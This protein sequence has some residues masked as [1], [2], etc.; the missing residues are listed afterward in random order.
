MIYDA[1]IV[2]YRVVCVQYTKT[3]IWWCTK[4]DGACIIQIL[5]TLLDDDN[6]ENPMMMPYN[7]WVLMHKYEHTLMH[8]VEAAV[9]WQVFF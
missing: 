7:L 6:S 9:S 3:M 5:C 1:Y 4:D 2:K 8:S